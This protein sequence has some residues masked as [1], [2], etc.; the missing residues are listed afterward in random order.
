M[1]SQKTLGRIIPVKG[2]HVLTALGGSIDE[3][4]P[5]T[6]DAGSSEGG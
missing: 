4:A 2:K 3:E 6:I 1:V 5:I